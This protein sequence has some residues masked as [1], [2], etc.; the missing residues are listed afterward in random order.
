MKNIQTRTTSLTWKQWVLRSAATVGLA[1]T[2]LFALNGE[3]SASVD[4]TKVNETSPQTT[5]TEA[6]TPV[7]VKTVRLGDRND[8]VKQVQ[9]KVGTNVDGIFGPKTEDA[10]KDFQAANQLQVDGIV[11]PKTMQALGI[12]TPTTAT[13]QTTSTN[14]TAKPIQ[15]AAPASNATHSSLIDVALDQLGAPYS[16]GGQSPQ[17]GFDCSGFIH[18]VFGTQGIQLPRSAQGLYDMASP[19]S[20]PNVG[21]L[22]FFT[23]T[24]ETDA[25]ITHAGIYIGNNSFIHAAS[26]GVEQSNL[27][28][29]YWQQ[30][31]VG[32]GSL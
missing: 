1:T 12:A 29:T 6:S 19:T 25:Y 16:W 9:E 21:D 13:T 14:E 17:T 30:H 2:A 27:N 7:T 5:T 15:T 22:V 10:V 32:S 26:S 28:N 31:Y 24:Y 3:A 18:Y 4:M 11:G 23:N 20:S 8:V